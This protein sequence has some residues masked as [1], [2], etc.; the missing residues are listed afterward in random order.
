MLYIKTSIKPLALIAIM[1]FCLSACSLFYQY[2]P[3]SSSDPSIVFGDQ[4]Q[5]KKYSNYDRTV[6]RQFFVNISP[7]T[8]QGCFAYKSI[9]TDLSDNLKI[10][11]FKPT[12]TI[13]S[14]PEP[15]AIRSFA[16]A[17]ATTGESCETDTIR[18]TP[19]PDSKYSVDVVNVKLIKD[20]T[21]TSLFPAVHPQ[22]DVSVEKILP[23]GTRIPV[24]VETL[25]KCK[26]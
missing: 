13:S 25:P 21:T 2:T 14:P 9:G 22:C 11:G 10:I 15:I 4:H 18:F 24:N 20:T 23:D 16:L 26:Y 12:K 7:Q 19:A 8:N 6:S 17:P 5:D 1:P 3:K